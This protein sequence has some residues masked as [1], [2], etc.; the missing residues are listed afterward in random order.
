M[1]E[2]HCFSATIASENCCTFNA[3][4]ISLIHPCVIGLFDFS[5]Q[6]PYFTENAVKSFMAYHE[7]RFTMLFLL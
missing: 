6:K 5:K 2:M 7:K 1:C 3:Q 4:P